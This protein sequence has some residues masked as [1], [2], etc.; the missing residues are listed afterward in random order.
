MCCFNADDVSD[1]KKINLNSQ[2]SVPNIHRE[3]FPA[4]NYVIEAFMGFIANDM[5]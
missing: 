1:V 3:K 5:T 4:N 2:M